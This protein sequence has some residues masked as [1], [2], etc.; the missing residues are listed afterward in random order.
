MSRRPAT[1]RRENAEEKGR[2]YLGEG[3]LVVRAVDGDTIRAVCRGS[4][5]FYRLG[6]D[7][8]QGWFCDC[9]ARSTCAHLHGLQ[10][11]TVVVGGRRR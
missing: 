10:L 7:P 5:D 11:V 1:T 8:G 4:G 9:P 3:R 6:H 2:R